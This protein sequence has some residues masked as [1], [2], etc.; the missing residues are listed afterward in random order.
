MGTPVAG[1]TTVVGVAADTPITLDEAQ[2][3]VED[4]RNARARACL[5]KIMQ[6]AEEAR[7]R[8]EA[9]A[10]LTAEG[11]VLARWRVVAL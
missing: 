6:F 1:G 9:V 5:E 7:C 10:Y 2:R 11:R 4:E 3:L 8:V